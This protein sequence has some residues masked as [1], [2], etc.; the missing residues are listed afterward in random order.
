MEIGRPR[1]IDGQ[2]VHD[3][4]LPI[5]NAEQDKRYARALRSADFIDE[6]DTGAA[7]PLDRD[8]LLVIIPLAV[9]VYIP[10]IMPARVDE[11]PHDVEP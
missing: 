10:R 11:R 8:A 1:R 4:L 2:A 6:R 7:L 3:L 9:G 5:I